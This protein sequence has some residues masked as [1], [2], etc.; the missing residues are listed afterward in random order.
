MELTPD[1]VSVGSHKKVCWKGA[2]GHEWQARV[3]DRVKK[4]TGCPYCTNERIEKGINDITALMPGLAEELAESED[5]RVYTINSRGMVT[6]KCKECGCEWDAQ[7]NTRVAGG[8]GCPECRRRKKDV[9]TEEQYIIRGVKKDFIR[10]L[11]RLSMRFYLEKSDADVRYDDDSKYGIPLDYYF[12]G[13][14]SV[15]MIADPLPAKNRQA[16][17]AT[18]CQKTDTA[19]IYIVPKAK[20]R[21]DNCHSIRFSDTRPGIWSKAIQTAFD[22]IGI[23]VDVDIRWDREELFRYYQSAHHLSCEFICSSKSTDDVGI[24]ISVS[25]V[26]N[27]RTDSLSFVIRIP[28]ILYFFSESQENI[29]Y[30]LGRK[31]APETC[32]GVSLSPRFLAHWT[33]CRS[34]EL[35]DL[36]FSKSLI[37]D[38]EILT[39]SASV[40]W[41]IL[42]FFSCRPD[43]GTNHC[44]C[45]HNYSPNISYGE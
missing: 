30:I 14:K 15:I 8:A 11:P 22:M 26:L 3:A 18:V 43:S 28:I 7:I 1:D 35:L 10:A 6:W 13:N 34:R 5:N 32:L 27:T 12:P 16:A 42:S 41:D 45:I 23:D 4:K 36:P 31:A 33:A 20:A 2:C 39:F 17:L 9:V 29:S 38:V 25:L 37:C 40:A 21:Y 19:L 44:Y 24:I